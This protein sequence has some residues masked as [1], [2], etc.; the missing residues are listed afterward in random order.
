MATVK[1]TTTN[2]ENSYVVTPT[3]MGAKL[4]QAFFDFL[5]YID[6]LDVIDEDG[7]PTTYREEYDNGGVLVVS[8]SGF[9]T[10]VWQIRRMTYSEPG[11]KVSFS[12]TCSLRIDIDDSRF[13]GHF[14]NM[15]ARF[16]GVELGAKG[17]FSLN[18]EGSGSAKIDETSY[19]VDGT[20]VKI[21]GDVT[22]ANY[23]ASGTLSKVT[24]TS[25][26]GESLVVSHS[27][28]LTAPLLNSIEGQTWEYFLSES[29]LNGRDQ[30]TGGSKNDSF[31]GFAGND[32]LLGGSGSDTL[33]GG[34]GNDSM[35][36]E[37][38][39]DAL[40]GTS[41]ND[42]LDGGSGNDTLDGG[43]GSDALAGGRGN[44]VYIINTKTDIVS[45]R[46]GQ[47]TDRVH[48]P[49]TYSLGDT[50]GA[51]RNYGGNVENLRLTGSSHI[52]G[53]GNGLNN[54]LYANNGANQLD[55][56]AGNDTVSYLYATRSSGSTGV[57]LDLSLLNASGQ[58]TA[59]GVSG[60]DRIK[61][62]EN[63]TGSNY[64]DTLTGNS[65]AN[66]LS[67][68][69]GNDDLSGGAGNDNLAGG[70]GNDSLSGGAG[71]DNLVG[72][73]GK[74][75][76]TG[77]SGRDTFDFNALSELGLGS[78]T[79]DVITDFARSQD[80]IDLSTLDANTARSGNQSFSAPVVGNHFS[81]AFTRVGELYFDPVADVLY[82]NTDADAAAEFSIQ[83]TGL[84]TLS[85]TDLIL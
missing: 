16:F 72:G 31:G 5:D 29:F 6:S 7:T 54:V 59:S 37:A 75:R 50:D 13:S 26:K 10:D 49:I 2:W 80:R 38:G 63:I 57:T 58:A 53:T 18:D 51:G 21:A 79:R 28:K 77:N 74:D 20:T 61:N 48:S 65:A 78:P 39:N 15:S 55:G 71:N 11:N 1:F 76:L 27:S 60:T 62:I 84:S 3:Q 14:S 68:G 85:A 52:N 25:A 12:M 19:K 30:I 40:Y 9:D 73:A 33:N 81:G 69:S 64:N 4:L 42:T 70:A 43:G 41:G 67:G 35:S 22:Y 24:V 44:D 83:I 45:E 32:T 36:G 8:G 47:G 56:G 34:S 82:G 46:S 23:A 66:A 17:D